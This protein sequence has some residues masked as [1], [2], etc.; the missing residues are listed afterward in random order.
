MIS[1]NIGNIED[2]RLYN[3]DYICNWIKV[4]L[5]YIN[6]LTLNFFEN[7]YK[8]FSREDAK[9]KVNYRNNLYLNCYIRNP[10][11]FRYFKSK[12]I[13]RRCISTK[14]V[15]TILTDLE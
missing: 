5:N 7:Y 9:L 6:S 3:S 14:F 11:S 2:T 1:F 8:I 10:H 15:L 12:I 13:G 4:L